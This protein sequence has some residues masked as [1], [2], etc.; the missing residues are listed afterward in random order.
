[1][2]AM[3]RHGDHLNVLTQSRVTEFI[4]NTRTNKV[5]GI[6]YQ[7][8][9]GQ[10]RQVRARKEIILSAGSINT[11]Q[12]LQLSGIGPAHVLEPLDVIQTIY[13]LFKL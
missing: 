13:F 9:D 11:A 1:M 5:I 6:K 4:W 12:L 7:D 8:I 2:P 10:I 3:K